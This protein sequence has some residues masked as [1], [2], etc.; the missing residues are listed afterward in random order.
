[1]LAEAVVIE[2][3]YTVEEY[4]DLEKTSEIRHEFVDGVLIPMPGESKIANKI[5]GNVYFQFRTALKKNVFE[6]FNHDVRT[7]LNNGK[8]YRY[9]DVVVAPIVDEEDTHAV[10]QPILI[11]EVFSEN[12]LKT[13]TVDKLKEYLSLPT[14][15]Y[16]LIVSQ[17]E[18]FVEVYSRNENKWEFTF[19]SQL[20]EVISLPILNAELAMKTVYEGVF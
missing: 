16:Y 3:K 12:S 17:T 13:D 1:M 5:A 8:T 20:D 10:M 15:Q 2:K 6:V 4:F 11:V 18:P 9:P 7:F 14:M 19:C